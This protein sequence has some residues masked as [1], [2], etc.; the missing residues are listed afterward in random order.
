LL[1]I[2]L[3]NKE[4]V[5]NMSYGTHLA[6]RLKFMNEQE[7]QQSFV[8]VKCFVDLCDTFSNCVSFSLPVCIADYISLR[9]NGISMKQ[10]KSLKT[11]DKKQLQW[12]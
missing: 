4:S 11:V 2:T 9:S 7:A 10:Q 1:S 5:E 12:Y 6:Q 3:L 8:I